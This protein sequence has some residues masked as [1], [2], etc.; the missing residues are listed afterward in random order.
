[1]D[2]EIKT[3]VKRYLEN[4]KSDVENMETNEDP[5]IAEMWWNLA[6]GAVVR[7]INKYLEGIE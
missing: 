1:M 2:E 5:S 6:L 4:V 7:I 3:I